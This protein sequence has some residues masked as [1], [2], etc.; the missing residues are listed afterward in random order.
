M[1]EIKILARFKE[2]INISLLD[3]KTVAI[4]GYHTNEKV[5]SELLAYAY[6]FEAQEVK[7]RLKNNL[8]EINKKLKQIHKGA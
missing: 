1:E 6:S 5:E 4:Q 2:I 3:N 8:K 7:E